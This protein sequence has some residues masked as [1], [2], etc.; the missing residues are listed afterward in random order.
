MCAVATACPTE[1]A[2]A[3]ADGVEAS[4]AAAIAFIDATRAS[5]TDAFPR[6]HSAATRRAARSRS[7]ILVPYHRK[8]CLAHSQAHFIS[9]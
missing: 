4:R 3:T 5:P 1:R 9:R 7:S 6:F 2:T 8:T